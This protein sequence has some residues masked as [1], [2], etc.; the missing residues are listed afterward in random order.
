VDRSRLA[1]FTGLPAISVPCG[2]TQAGLPVALQFV[3]RRFEDA[4]LIAIA[5]RFAGS[6]RDWE[7]RHPPLA[8]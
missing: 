4:A 1:N 2:L 5:R 8:T 6:E 7:P 3:G